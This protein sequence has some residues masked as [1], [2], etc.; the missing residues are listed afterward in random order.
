[1]KTNYYKT[2]IAFLSIFF[3][4][5]CNSILEKELLTSISDQDVW[6]DKNLLQAYVNDL[7]SRAPYRG[8]FEPWYRYTDEATFADGNQ[9]TLTLGNMNKSSDQLGYWDYSIV[10]AYNVFLD[11]IKNTPVSDDLK[12]TWEGEV[13][14]MRAIYY[15]EMAIRYGGVP[16]VQTVLDPNA[17]VKDN[18]LPRNTEEEVFKFIESEIDKSIDLLR[19][20]GS[21]KD[22]F[23]QMTALAYKART[24]LWAASIAKYSTVQLN[25]LLGIPA[26]QANYYYNLALNAAEQVINSNKYSLYDKYSDK[27]RNYQM[28]FI[29]KDN[30]EVILQRSFNGSELGHSY[31]CNNTPP[32]YRLVYGGQCNP[33]WE[34]VLSYENIDGSSDQPLIG[35]D[36]LYDSGYDLLKKKDPRLHAT[37]LYQGASWQGSVVDIH[38]AT[39]PNKIPNPSSLLSNIGETYEGIP[40]VGKDFSGSAEAI[41]KSGFYIKKYM[42]ESLIKPGEKK[43]STNWIEIRLA[44]MYLIAA[45]AAFETGNKTKAVSRLNAIRQRAGITLLDENNITLEKVRNERK[46][47]LAFENF[48]YWDLRRW[49][50]SEYYVNNG[51]RFQGIKAI[52][53]STSGKYYFLQKDAETFVRTFRVEHYYNPITTSRINNNPSLIENIG[54]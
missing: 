42:D 35:K 27:I 15:F 7:Y 50:T 14:L 36:Y 24:M 12:A 17:P 40:Q 25:G 51:A 16:I 23:N 52:F 54:Y 20:A 48:R 38:E 43:S 46:I 1:M 4:S 8:V 28:L 18:M 22:K 9:S 32:S 3:L 2:L 49:R 10:R 19:N 31:D 5:A 37:I 26:S 6:N 44:E 41:T 34:M 29:E 11:K 45:E 33:V 53:H 30:S 39:D 21:S 13:R 47:E